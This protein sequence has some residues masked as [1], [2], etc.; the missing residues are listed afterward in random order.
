MFADRVDPA[1][2]LGAVTTS[3]AVS[4]AVTPFAVRR[5]NEP[6]HVTRKLAVGVLYTVNGAL[7]GLSWP[8]I[9]AMLSHWAPSDELSS[10]YAVINT[11]VPGG[12]LLGNLITGVVYREISS[13]FF[14]SYFI[15][16][17]SFRRWRSR[18]GD[19]LLFLWDAKPILKISINFEAELTCYSHDFYFK[20]LIQTHSIKKYH[21]FIY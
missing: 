5:L 6:W 3:L 7:I 12:L 4:S 19:H 18:S 8:F 10:M 16:A 1:R 13:E 14:Y 2:A 21:D 20:F 15:F 17:V 11:G 9:N